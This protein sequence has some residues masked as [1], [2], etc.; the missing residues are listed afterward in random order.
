M[1]KGVG[2]VRMLGIAAVLLAIAFFA[3]RLVE[4]QE[5]SSI[6]H[7]EY[8]LEKMNFS[9]KYAKE[10]APSFC[11]H[12]STGFRDS[13]RV[14]AFQLSDGCDG[15][16]FLEIIQ[17]TEGWTVA[18]VSEEDLRGFAESFWYPELIPMPDNTVFDAWFYRETREPFG[19]ARAKGCFS[20]I[21]RIG[22]GFEFAVFDVETEMVIFVDQFG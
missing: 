17:R 7:A 22:Y 4:N 21:G 2:N 16:D 11:L 19:S 14:T 18:P 3:G 1:E 13:Y 9:T 20:S 12:G 5:L 6:N 15:E 8:A 10:C